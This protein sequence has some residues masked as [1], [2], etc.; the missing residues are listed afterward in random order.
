MKKFLKQEMYIFG[1]DNGKKLEEQKIKIYVKK[2]L[3]TA[4]VNDIEEL[5]VC[6]TSND[7][8]LEKCIHYILDKY[9]INTKREFFVM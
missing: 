7:V 4:N 6:E 1:C 2:G 9:R 5:F 3:Q 8:L